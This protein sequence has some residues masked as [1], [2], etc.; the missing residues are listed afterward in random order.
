MSE[1]RG[2]YAGQSVGERRAQRREKLRTAALDV[3]A[4]QGLLGLKVRA[5]CTRAGLNDRYFYE[6]YSHIDRLIMEVVEEQQAQILAELLVVI[7]AEPADTRIRLRAV[8]ETVVAAVADHPARRRLFLDM[9]STD[10]LRS[11]RTE[12]V[13]MAMNIMLDQGRELL[14]AE[15]VTGIHAEL[16][17]RTVAYGGLDILTEW[18]AGDLDI[19]RTQLIDFLVAMILTSSE[20]TTT[21]RREMAGAG[22]AERPA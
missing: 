15:A 12:L 1:P 19:D 18:L 20:I 4:E 13:N 7:A 22:G 10:E 5:L 14:G 11:R 2:R 21:V 3:L 9:Q 16:A 8:V 17:A 6:S